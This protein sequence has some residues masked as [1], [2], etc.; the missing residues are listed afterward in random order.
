MF[1]TPLSASDTHAE[2]FHT[3]L[4]GIPFQT[5]WIRLSKVPDYSICTTYENIVDEPHAPR[6]IGKQCFSHTKV[7]VFLGTHIF[8]LPHT[9][10]LP[11]SSN[12][13]LLP[14]ILVK[15][16]IF[17]LSFIT[18]HP[19]LKSLGKKINCSLTSSI[20]MS[21]QLISLSYYRTLCSTLNL[22]PSPPLPGYPN[23]NHY[24]RASEVI[25]GL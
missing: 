1:L 3:L 14:L 24:Q 9:Y 21:V 10:S 20:S 18:L 5:Y 13:L 6:N 8:L 7:S 19:I 11:S 12:A 22:V 15:V 25:K 23:I 17:L 16:K 4:N 2:L